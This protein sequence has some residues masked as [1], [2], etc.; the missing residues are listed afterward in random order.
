MR[1]PFSLPLFLLVFTAH[2]FAQNT[3]LPTVSAPI[4]PAS[5]VANAGKAIDLRSHFAV[6][7]ITGQVVQFTTAGFGTFNVEMNSTVA[8]NT[9]ANFLNYVNSNRFANTLVHR[10]KPSLHIIQGGGYSPNT[11]GTTFT[12]Y[13]TVPKNAQIAMEAGNTLTHARGTIAMARTSQSLNTATSEWFINTADNFGNFDSAS[14]GT[15]A[16]YAVFGRV[17]GTGMNVV[18]PIA[19]LPVLGGDI[20]V[21]Q[22]S[23]TSTSVSVD[24]ASIPA[25]FGTGWVLLGEQVASLNIVGNIGLITLT[26]NADTDIFFPTTVHYALFQSPFGELP[27]LHNLTTYGNG[28]LNL[29]ELVKMTSI[30]AVPVFPGSTGG[31]GVVSFSATSSNPL[32]NAWTTGSTLHLVPT[33]NINGSSTVTV[34]GT[35]SNGNAVS[36][37]FNVTVN[38]KLRDLNGDSFCDLVFQNTGT[39]QLQEWLLDGTGASINFGTGSGIK[40][41]GYLYGGSLPGWRLAGVG[42]VDGDSIPDLI[43]QNTSTG[44]IQAWLLDGSGSS[45]NFTTRSGI[46]SSGYLYGGTLAG[47]Q[48]AGIADVDGDGKADIIF[49]NTSTGQV[50]AWFLDGTGA[51]VNFS[52][53]SGIK[54]SGYLYGGSLVGWQLSGIGDVNGDGI[55]DLVFQNGYTGQVFAFA[56]DDTGDSIN[57]STG[58][59][60]KGSGYLYGGSLLGWR[61]AGVWD[62]NGDGIP[63]LLFQNSSTGQ[64]YGFFLDG[65]G[66]S[67]NFSTGSG[68]KGADYLYGG[69]LPGWLAY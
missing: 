16:S 7:G 44:Q 33:K 56:L 30:Q 10:S 4:P 41:T 55:P 11:T 19:A 15:A 23:K 2:L 66:A 1:L 13:F 25:N 35:D 46:K 63:D 45:I 3:D 5:I 20:T 52:T 49:Q 17:T 42:D 34:T 50:L 24:A 58:S 27:V 37:S 12:N 59:G 26:G 36:T 53:G 28:S 29:T 39:G 64:V 31:P 54:G 22:S 8:P 6:T 40:S 43:F 51:S 68:I 67:V 21:T 9:V 57:F 69:S 18:D 65:T 62:L 47:W 38:R 14:A 32:V 61:L 60:T 48:V